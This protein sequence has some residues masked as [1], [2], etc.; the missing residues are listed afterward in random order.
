MGD[1]CAKRGTRSMASQ[2]WSKEAS[3]LGGKRD[4]TQIRDCRNGV[5]CSVCSDGYRLDRRVSRS[6]PGSETSK[7]DEDDQQPES[8]QTAC[9]RNHHG[10]VNSHTQIAPLMNLRPRISLAGQDVILSDGLGI[11]RIPRRN[12][13]LPV[14]AVCGVVAT[15][16][17]FPARPAGGYRHQISNVNDQTR[18]LTCCSAIFEP[19]LPWTQPT[20]DDGC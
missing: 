19:Y 2:G 8:G 9:I 10:T 7:A 16:P 17:P 20:V 13:P 12:A 11:A 14:N 5:C 18:S 6:R 3:M 4:T 1:T 15:A